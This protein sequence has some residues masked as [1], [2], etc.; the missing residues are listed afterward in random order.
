MFE[1]E[2]F[3]AASLLP[4]LMIA[5]SAGILSFLSPC[6]LPIVPPYL[7][8]MGGVSVTD[9]EGDKAARRRAVVAALFFVLGL[10][11]VFLI[12]GAGASALGR[13][14]ASYRPY[15]EI[16]AGIVVIIFGLHFIGL[17]RLKF[18]DREMRV[19]AGDQG[20]SAF[21]AY[22]LGLAFAFGWTPCLGPILSA[23]LSLAGSQADVGKGVVL[24]GVYAMGLGVPFL[25]VA[26]F[27]PQMKRPMAWMKR[28]MGMIEKTSGVLLIAVGL[29]MAT[30]FLSVFAF[31]LL[32]A[33]PVLQIFG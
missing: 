22:F 11:T 23:I 30:G 26:A 15:M 1:T 2:T 6:V 20:G 7:A 3:L 25:L 32:E 17:F 24:L 19:E 28:N 14:L 16:A 5:F 33:F 8:Y 10:S 4:A 13:M 12:L 31:W 21:G 27:F 29:A 18:L 9:M